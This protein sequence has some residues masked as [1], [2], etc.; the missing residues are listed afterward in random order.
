MR[1]AFQVES[2]NQNAALNEIYLMGRY[3]QS[4]ETKDTAE[5]LLRKLRPLSDKECMDLIREVQA[6]YRLPGHASSAPVRRNARRG[7]STPPARC[8]PPT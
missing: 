2:T 8:A 7:R 5:S 3:T 6:S 1:M 4:Q